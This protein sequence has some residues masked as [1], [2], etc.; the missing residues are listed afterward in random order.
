MTRDEAREAVKILEA[1]ADGKTVQI[2]LKSPHASETDWQ[3][4]VFDENRIPQHWPPDFMKWE[5]RIKPEPREIL[6]YDS[7][8]P[9]NTGLTDVWLGPNPTKKEIEQHNLVR[10]REVLE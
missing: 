3:N 4:V 7:T 10:F 9:R 2:R 5:Y 8:D 6:L 1:Y